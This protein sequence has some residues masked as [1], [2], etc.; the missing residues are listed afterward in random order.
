MQELDPQLLSLYKDVSA[1]IKATDEISFKL[2]GAV[3]LVSGILSGV[4][5]VLGESNALEGYEAPAVVALAV[6]GLFITA[7][8]FRWELRNIQKCN[9]LISRAARLERQLFSSEDARIQFDGIASDD[10]LKAQE[11][12]DVQISSVFKFPWGKTQSVKLV[13]S[14]SLGAWLI[15]LIIATVSLARSI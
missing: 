13:Y 10:D 6:L 12:Q 3:P 14:A 2:L 11:M 7:G 1:N 15:P 5:T 4:L 9:W 8:L